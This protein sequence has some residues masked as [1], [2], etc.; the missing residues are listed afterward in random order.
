MRAAGYD[1]VDSTTY[2]E[3]WPGG[4]HAID[5]HRVNT[6]QVSDQLLTTG[7]SQTLLDTFWTLLRNPRFA[8]SSYPLVSVLGRTTRQ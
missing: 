3:A 5:L 8:V 6:E 7:I 1:I 4:G 2:A